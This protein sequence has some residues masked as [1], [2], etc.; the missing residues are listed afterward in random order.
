VLTG[1]TRRWQTA[2]RPYETARA[3]GGWEASS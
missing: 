1:S 2:E 3:P